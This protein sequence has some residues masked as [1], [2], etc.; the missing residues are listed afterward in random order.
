MVGAFI[1]VITL[2][3]IYIYQHTAVPTASLAAA[4]DEA[5]V[6]YADNG[7]V[8]GRIGSENHQVISYNQ[9]PKQVI[10][11][12]LAAEDRN[13]FNEGGVSPT[14]IARAAYEDILN[15][16]DQQ[17]GSTITQEFVRQYYEGIGTDKTVSRKVKEIFVAMK[18]GRTESKQWILQQYL[19]TI[20]LGEGAQGIAAA[21][22][23]YFNIP[24]SHLN[25]ITWAQA[26]MLAAIIQQPSTYPL[27]QYHA[28]LVA[29]WRGEVLAGLVKMGAITPQYAASL[30]FPSFGDHQPQTFGTAVWDPY[31]VGT[32]ENELTEVDHYTEPE[33][34]DNG[35]K[36]VTTVDPAKMNA[37]YQSVQTEQNDMAEQGE[38]F[39]SY[40][41]VGAVLV[42]PSNASIV[43][44]YGGPGYAGSKYNGVGK[45]ITQKFCIKISCTVNL[46]LSRE[47][48]G[49]SFKPYILSTAVSEGMNVQTSKLDGLDDSCIPPDTQPAAY[50]KPNPEYPN[51]GCPA[52]WDPMSNDD[53]SENGAF[54]PQQAMTLSVNT[55]YAD[56]WHKVAGPDGESVLQMATNYGVNVDEAGLPTIR[57]EAG[58]ALGQGVLSVAEQADTLATIDNDGTWNQL[59]IVKSITR[60]SMSQPTLLKPSHLVLDQNN[61]TLNQEMDSQVQYGMEDVVLAGTG[62]G[63]IAGL[64]PSREV[65][66]KTGTTNTAQSAFFIGAIPQ[67][68]LAIGMFTNAQCA[69]TCTGKNATF[70]NNETL[71]G[72]GGISQGDGG[73]WP[74]SIWNAYALQEFNQLPVDSFQIQPAS[75]TG[76]SWI[77]APANMLKAKHKAKPKKHTPN[78][79]VTGP[80]PNTPG[81]YPTPTETCP[82]GVSNV[83]CVAPSAS[84]P[85]GGTNATP[86][87]TTS[88]IG[89]GGFGTVSSPDAGRGSAGASAGAAVAGSVVA[90]P[91]ALFLVRKRGR[92]GRRRG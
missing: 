30:K 16:G 82:P 63:A 77:L 67:D 72:L 55:A 17:G 56:L 43:A 15:G 39:Q 64:D 29:R 36:I 18:I 80:P 73:T 38:P 6:I 4:G 81:A 86:T 60:D 44:M 23:T 9:I 21:A 13:F 49:S 88:S 14:G 33:L 41:H 85:A 32:V 5:S 66:G 65:I 50:L 70:E 2:G 35:Y 92:R 7:T 22:E 28:D 68:A 87:P 52:E 3:V 31:V 26:A 79:G 91:L 42:N 24:V 57:D 37:L 40:M 78:P 89:I 51:N 71:N 59:H 1:V 48:V 74:A 58:I 83:D 61:P 53:S 27:P 90:L 46:A 54:S 8:I 76:Q 45:V 47:Q 84:G 25:D 11:A 62:T 69:P 19:N 34:E 10:D 75:F 12:T 20:Y